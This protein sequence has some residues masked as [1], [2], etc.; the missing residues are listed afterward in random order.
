MNIRTPN[1]KSTTAGKRANRV[2]FKIETKQNSPQ[3]GTPDKL[4]YCA[5]LVGLALVVDELALLELEAVLVFVVV[6]EDANVLWDVSV[7]LLVLDVCPH[8]VPTPKKR[9]I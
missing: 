5:V 1:N 7:A 6:V 8:V 2:A 9:G 4:G 3:S